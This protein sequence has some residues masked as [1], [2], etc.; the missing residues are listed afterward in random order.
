MVII[1]YFILYMRAFKCQND[2]LNSYL[3]NNLQYNMRPQ[4]T[5]FYILKHKKRTNFLLLQLISLEQICLN[6]FFLDY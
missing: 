1:C 4:R 2:N 6:F 5:R 3:E